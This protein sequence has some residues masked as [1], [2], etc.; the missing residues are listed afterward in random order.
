[1]R[2]INLI[3]SLPRYV[4]D[5]PDSMP[6]NRLCEGDLAIL[7]KVI[8]RLESQVKSLSAAMPAMTRDMGQRSYNSVQPSL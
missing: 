7:M 8:E 5:S 6:S 3:D 2:I 4:A 1:M